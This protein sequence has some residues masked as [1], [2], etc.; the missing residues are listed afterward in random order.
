MDMTDD[1]KGIWFVF[2]WDMGANPLFVENSEID[3]RRHID[4]YPYAQV[5]FWEFGTEWKE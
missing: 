2:S 5:R 4:D 1:T 3:A